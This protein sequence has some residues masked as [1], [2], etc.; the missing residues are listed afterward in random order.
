[1]TSTIQLPLDLASGEINPVSEWCQRWTGRQPAWT[2]R[3]AGGFNRDRYRVEPVTEAVARTYVAAHHYL[4]DS[5][6]AAIRRYGLFLDDDDEGGLVGVA[7]FG[8]PVSSRTL[9]NVFPDLEPYREALELSR[10]VLEG[11]RLAGAG[12]P[13]GASTR[14]PAGRAPGNAESFFVAHCFRS[15]AAEGIRGVVAFADPVPRLMGNGT[16]VGGHVGW[17]YQ[18]MNCRYTGRGTARTL[19][20]LP[21]ATVLNDRSRQKVSGGD[22]MTT[23]S[24]AGGLLHALVRTRSGQVYLRSRE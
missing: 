20:I 18:G 6:P 2:H 7:V 4:G 22:R 3:S 8:A 17:C 16:V 23:P 14:F 21:D 11:P 10:L 24:G 13:P 5:Y 12:R 1:M 19:T 9:T 15:L